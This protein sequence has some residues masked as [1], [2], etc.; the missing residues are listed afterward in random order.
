M[1]GLRKKKIEYQQNTKYILLN[2]FF[3]G[4]NVI[5]EIKRFLRV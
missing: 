3:L 4:L 1:F 2:L 5:I